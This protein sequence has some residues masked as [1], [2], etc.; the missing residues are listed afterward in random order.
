M[1]FPSLHEF[2]ATVK[3]EAKKE[4]SPTPATTT[5]PTITPTA[6]AAPVGPKPPPL[7]LPAAS[8]NVVDKN[9]EAGVLMP[10]PMGPQMPT[11][12]GDLALY[13]AYM[14]ACEKMKELLGECENLRKANEQLEKERAELRA[15]AIEARGSSKLTKD[16]KYATTKNKHLFFSIYFRFTAAATEIYVC[17]WFVVTLNSASKKQPKGE[18]EFV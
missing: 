7:P 16:E 3:Q 9:G 1:T 2:L 5:T 18:V 6:V 8:S 4:V 10:M 13:P 15:E 12:P 17:F 11:A 14:Q